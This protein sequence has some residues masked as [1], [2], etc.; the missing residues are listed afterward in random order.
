VFAASIENGLFGVREFGVTNRCFFSAVLTTDNFDAMDVLMQDMK[1]VQIESASPITDTRAGAEIFR[2]PPRRYR[3]RTDVQAC[4][5]KRNVSTSQIQ[6]EPCKKRLRFGSTEYQH[7]P[8]GK[9]VALASVLERAGKRRRTCGMEISVEEDFLDATESGDGGAER[10][11][12]TSTEESTHGNSQ[13]VPTVDAVVMDDGGVFV[14]VQHRNG[15]MQF[16]MV[17]PP[18]VDSNNM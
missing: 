1:P 11:H 17:D 18:V 14:R 8:S 6:R 2:L 9:R 3:V 5:Q 15:I 16:I 10:H 4:G 12:F 13:A 7:Y